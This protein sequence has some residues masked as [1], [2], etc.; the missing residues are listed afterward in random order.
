LSHTILIVDDSAL[1]RRFL[2]SYIEQHGEWNVCGEAENGKTA[3]ERV[4]ELKP[5]VVILD[6]QMPVMNGLEAA[7]RISRIAP[8]T[9]MLM[10]TMHA[11]EQLLKE[12][13][14]V[15]IKTVLSKSDAG[16]DRLF[17]ALEGACAGSE[18]STG[19]G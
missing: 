13:E 10:Y 1:V 9:G 2:R 17:V 7:R 11:G 19:L 12:A 16:T 8:R 4:E 3:V 5:D 14:S 6:F 18:R 15:G